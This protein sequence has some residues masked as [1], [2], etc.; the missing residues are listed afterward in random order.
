MLI[1]AGVVFAVLRWRVANILVVSAG[2]VK[3]IRPAF[4]PV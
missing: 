4:Y 1:V 2:F 3:S